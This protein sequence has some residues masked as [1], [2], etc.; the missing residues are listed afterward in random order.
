MV[1]WCIRSVD[2]SRITAD[3]DQGNLITLKYVDQKTRPE[4]QTD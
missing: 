3:A 1:V 4:R 2:V